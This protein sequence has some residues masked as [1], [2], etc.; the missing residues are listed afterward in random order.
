[1]PTPGLPRCQDFVASWVPDLDRCVVNGHST[2]LAEGIFAF[3]FDNKDARVVGT[4]ANL[5]VAH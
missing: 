1:L 3:A 4:V 5:D 2:H